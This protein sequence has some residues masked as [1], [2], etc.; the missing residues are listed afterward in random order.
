MSNV[1]SGLM[2]SMIGKYMLRV[3]NLLSTVLI[4]RLLT[5][6]EI[7]TFAIASSFVMILTEVKLLGA[8]AYLIRAEV[9]DEAKIR[10]A[11][12]M[13]ILMC[14]GISAA[15][16][17]GSGGL[18]SFFRHDEIQQVFIILA[19][20]FLLAPYISVPDALLARSYRFKEI[21][22]IELSAA[23]TQFVVTL[24][25]VYQ[26]FSFYA[27]AWGQFSSM[28]CR[29]VLS[30]YF[31]RDTKIYRPGF[32]GLGE[33]ARLGLF[34]SAANIVRRIHYSASD[35]V[36][37]RQGTPGEVGV[38]SRGMGFIDFI[39][40]IVLD[41][42]GGVAQPYMSEL[43]RRGVDIAAAY[44]KTTAL[45]CSLVW[46]IL[47]VAGF[48]ALPAIRLLFGDQWDQS[49]PIAS[50]LAVWMLVKVVSF[51]SP[52][53]LIAVG[54]ESMMFKRDLSCFVL[55]IASLVF[56]YADGLAAMAVAFLV[57]GVVEGLITLWM[58]QRS[59]QLPVGIF[60]R[61]LFKP[62]L[63][64]LVCLA[65][66]AGLDQAY[67]FAQVSPLVVFAMLAVSIP[68]LWLSTTKLLGLQIYF[69]VTQLLQAIVRRLK[70]TR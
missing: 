64:A 33:I 27:L 42:V 38:F 63:V 26:G 69:E 24:A 15:L 13:T 47:A 67:P 29:F 56:S 51:F 11:Y 39:S 5:P 50:V 40:Q 9:L 3:V 18:A 35:L 34:T 20:S 31:T 10:K 61:S 7:G 44:I 62:A 48:A 55:L 70:P 6:A 25:L 37:G 14:W 41:G 30:L 1:R 4:A 65:G 43:K 58:L 60:I 46:P 45:L 59:V 21:S 49:A 53:L 68:L 22:I 66:A 23:P 52:Q 54:Q 36:I 17:L 12:G 2:F 16:I 57:N 8:N 19:L 28:V 32:N